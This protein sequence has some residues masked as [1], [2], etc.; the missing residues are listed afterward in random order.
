MLPQ[1]ATGIDQMYVLR[2]S[3]LSWS[4]AS[5]LNHDIGCLSNRLMEGKAE[6]ADGCDQTRTMCFG[7]ALVQV[8]PR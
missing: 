8:V 7:R 4:H 3:V 1:H 2:N 6:F 5:A